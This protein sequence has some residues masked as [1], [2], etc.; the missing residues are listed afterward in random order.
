MSIT[1]QDAIAI[2]ECMAL[3]GSCIWLRSK[4]F[5]YADRRRKASLIAFG[6]VSLA[7]L[8]DLIN[9]SSSRL[10]G[11]ERVVSWIGLEQY[12]NLILGLVVV[13][14]TLACLSLV[15]GL[16]GKGDPRRLA[17]LWFC[18]LLIP[19]VSLLSSYGGALY[20]EWHQATAIRNR[21]SVLAGQ[22]AISC[23]HVTPHTNP[24]ASS[25]CVIKSFENHKPFF[26][27]YDT[28]RI[29]IDSHFIDGLA[30][31][32]SGNLYDVE[33]SSM[34]WSAEGLSST[35]QLLDGR[36][37]FVEPCPKPIILRQSIYMGLTCLQRITESPILS[38]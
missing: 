3:A 5:S 11:I 32:N 38:K 29:R 4:Q 7:V 15:F 35:T 6:C 1:F 21:L 27:I 12:P 26:V 23:G 30:G 10:F 8:L 13:L 34:G 22:G 28:Q 24:G 25:E 31:D 19:N 9:T 36:H 20:G 33:F 18:V 17:L 2:T 14:G 16:L 37:I